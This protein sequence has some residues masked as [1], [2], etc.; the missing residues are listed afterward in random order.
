MTG[1]LTSDGIEVC[2]VDQLTKGRILIIRP[3]NF[4]S[5]EA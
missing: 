2:K 4:D 3:S 1:Q 5:C